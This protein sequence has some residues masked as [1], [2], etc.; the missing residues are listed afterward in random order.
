METKIENKKVEGQTKRGKSIF[1][2]IGVFII[3]SLLVVCGV[4]ISKP[5]SRIATLALALTGSPP[6]NQNEEAL[7]DLIDL[8]RQPLEKGADC[9]KRKGP[10]KKCSHIIVNGKNADEVITVLEG[11]GF[12]RVKNDGGLVTATQTG[13]G[14]V[15]I[16]NKGAVVTAINTGSGIMKIKNKATGTVSVTRIGNGNTTLNTTGSTIVALSYSGNGDVTFPPAP[17]ELS[18]PHIVVTGIH[19]SD[20]M[21]VVT[22]GGYI[23]VVNNGA[24]VAATQTGSGKINIVNNGQ[25]MAATNTGTGTM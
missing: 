11:D 19:A 22:G 15:R 8:S 23:A 20:V 25:V 12:I 2:L 18:V 24:H 5:D 21:P 4:D 13:D 1:T 16:D 6:P 17:G 14:T 10:N 3:S 9:K 7:N